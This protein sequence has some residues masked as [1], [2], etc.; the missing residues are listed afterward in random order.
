MKIFLGTL[1]LKN[2]VPEAGRIEMESTNFKIYSKAMT[3]DGKPNY[4]YDMGAV[5]LQRAVKFTKNIQPISLPS[6]S[7]GNLVG[8]SAIVSGWGKTENGEDAPRSE[9]L[10]YARMKIRK[11]ELCNKVFKKEYSNHNLCATGETDGGSCRGDS[12][13]PLTWINIMGMP[14]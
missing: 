8:V 3:P 2:D 13:G 4:R 5:E 12:G 1:F 9:I 7:I 11:L 6:S 10:L 14:Y